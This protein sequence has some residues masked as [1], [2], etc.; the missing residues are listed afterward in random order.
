MQA[1]TA[2]RLS[3]EVSPDVPVR[4]WVL[5]LPYEIR[6][7]LAWDGELL[8]AVLAVFLRVVYRWYRKRAREEG[9]GDARCGSVTGACPELVE[10]YNALGRP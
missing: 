2:A 6:F 7:R 5:S 8:S 1:D 10:G 9:H 4:Q 3:D